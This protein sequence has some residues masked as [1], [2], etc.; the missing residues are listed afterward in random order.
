[1]NSREFRCLV[2]S[3]NV[4]LVSKDQSLYSKKALNSISATKLKISPTNKYT[5]FRW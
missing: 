1:L 3:S 2:N 5:T 4:V